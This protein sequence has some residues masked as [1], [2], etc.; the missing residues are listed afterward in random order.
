VGDDD[1]NTE[2]GTADATADATPPQHRR[3][4]LVFLVVGVVLAAGLAVGLFTTAGSSP[5]SGR[6]GAG[7]AAPTFSLPRL[8]GGAAVGIPADGANG[9]RPAVLL[10]YASDCV[11]CHAEIPALARAYRAQ[12]RHPVAVVGVAAADP[13]PAAFAR[14]SGVSFPVG[15]D[16]KLDV[17]EGRYAFTAIPEAVFVKADGSIDAIHYGAI[18]PAQLAAGERRL[19]AS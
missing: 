16:D 15:L 14:A 4:R 9:T 11:P 13:S 17:T 19:L 7:S 5:S 18:T 3:P 12:P 8:G 10:F 1:R 2:A 6:P